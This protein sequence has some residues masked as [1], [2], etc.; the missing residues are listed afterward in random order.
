[1]PKQ[2]LEK[3]SIVIPCYNA[4]GYLAE[5]LQA[6]NRQSVDRHCKLLLRLCNTIGFSQLEKHFSA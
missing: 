3:I 2:M 1:M 6:F 5:C 4:S